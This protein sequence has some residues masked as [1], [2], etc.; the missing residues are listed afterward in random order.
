[1]IYPEARYSITGTNSVIPDSLAKMIKKLGVPVVSL[2]SHGHHL[3]QPVWNLTNKRK[4][5]NNRGY[6]K[7][8]NSL[9]TAQTLVLKQSIK[10]L[11][12]PF[13]MMTT[14]GNL[15]IKSRLKKKI[16]LKGFIRSYTNVQ[17]ATQ[18]KGWLRLIIKLSAQVAAKLMKWIHL[19]VLKPKREKL[20]SRHIPDWYEWERTEVRKELEAGTYHFEHEVEIESL[21]NSTGFL[22]LWN[23]QTNSIICKASLWAVSGVKKSFYLKK[24]R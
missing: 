12:I 5:K 16:A 15:I 19:D 23:R 13:I 21:P 10:L 11:M 8:L 7:N 4:I 1:M 2:I 3:I 14:N 22:S 17:V 24:V 9:K 20:S 18:K 6:D